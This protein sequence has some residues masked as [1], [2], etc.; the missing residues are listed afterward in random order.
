MIFCRPRRFKEDNKATLVTLLCQCLHCANAL[1]DPIGFYLYAI[2]P[3]YWEDGPIYTVWSI[4][5]TLSKLS[6]Y[7]VYIWR[8]HITFA[9]TLYMYSCSMYLPLCLLWMVQMTTMIWYISARP[10]FDDDSNTTLITNTVFFVLDFLLTISIM[11]LFI[12]P[13]AKLMRSLKSQSEDMM[14]KISMFNEDP[15]ENVNGDHEADDNETSHFEADSMDFAIMS[16]TYTV[17]DIP[18]YGYREREIVSLDTSMLRDHI[19]PIIEG[20]GGTLISN[21]SNHSFS[22]QGQPRNG[23]F[24]KDRY[25]SMEILTKKDPKWNVKQQ[26]LLGFA[27]RLGLLAMLALLSSFLYQITWIY[28]VAVHHD[29][30]PLFWFTYTWPVDMLINSICLFLSYR[31]TNHLY[32]TICIERLQCHQLC[33]KCVECVF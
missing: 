19:E 16:K 22:D 15:F 24:V 29:D 26:R 13:I 25:G 18:L 6:L 5:W 1:V 9:G 27:T 8:L 33:M 31:A 7:L 20:G 21:P 12:V 14:P 3:R 28:S 2:S 10:T 17:R 4:L 23:K 30:D 32:G 11:V